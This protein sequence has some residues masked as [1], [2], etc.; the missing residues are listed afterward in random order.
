MRLARDK[1]PVRAIRIA[2]ARVT[3]G[4]ASWHDAL[5][6]LALLLRP[7]AD[8]AMALSAHF[9]LPLV[10]SQVHVTWVVYAK[11]RSADLLIARAASRHP[12]PPTHCTF[13]HS[14]RL[15]KKNARGRMTGGFPPP[16]Q[17]TRRLCASTAEQTESRVSPGRVQR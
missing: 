2:H 16:L 4:H 10:L 6:S 5:S 15:F 3:D 9:A 11:R 8:S 17:P 7:Y 13:P 1:Y 14:A 12:S